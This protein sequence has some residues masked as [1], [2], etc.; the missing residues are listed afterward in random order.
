MYVLYCDDS[1]ITGKTD[2]EID[3]V[4]KDLKGQKLDL[5]DEGDIGDF[6]GVKIQKQSDGTMSLS[7]P[8]LIDQI[9]RDCHMDNDDISSK[10]TPLPSGKVV[11]RF[12]GSVPFDDHF[13]MRTVIGRMM[14]LEKASRPDISAAV[15]MLARY[16]SC[17]KKEHGKL[18]KHVVAYLKATRDK[19][20]I[21]KVDK[22][23]SFD[24]YVDASFSGDYVK[25]IDQSDDPSSA[26]SR[27]GLVIQY[28]GCPILW[29]SALQTECAMSSTESEVLALSQAM[30]DTLPLIWLMREIHKQGL[31]PEAV[32]PKIHCKM[33]EDNSGALTICTMP[34][35]RARTKHIN[36]K[37]FFFRSFVDKEVTIHK[38]STELQRADYLTKNL[39]STLHRRHRLS[40]QGW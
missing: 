27:T 24:C 31:I 4:I 19:G 36:T 16:A 39:N 23:H 2:R 3:Q 37:Y 8:H 33:F 34:K 7:Q 17:P 40:V 13:P 20:I 28:H 32:I 25:D 10:D 18:V 38:I 1:I 9:L 22:S 35:I 5:T 11:H 6:L 30:R 29:R 26:R 14:Y 15:H 12:T 21:Y